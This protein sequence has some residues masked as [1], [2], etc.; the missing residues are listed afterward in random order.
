MLSVL[1]KAPR[2]WSSSRAASLNHL[3]YVQRAR[4]NAVDEV[5]HKTAKAFENI[6]GSLL[7]NPRTEYRNMRVYQG[8]IKGVILDWAGTVLD[9]GVYSPAV[10]FLKV[11]DQEGVPITMEEAREPMGRHKKVH[12]RMVTQIDSVRKRWR[13]KFGRNPNEEDVE[14]MFANF[15]PQQLACL[16]EYSQMITGAV[17]TVDILQKDLKLKI[18]STTGFT[19]PMVDILKKIAAEHGYVPDCY[20]AADEVPQAR[21]YP[22]M[23]WLNAIKLDINPIAAIVKVD[24]TVDG[25]RE[26]T[27]AGCWSVGLARTGNYVALNEDEI[28][29]LTEEEYELKLEK[30]YETLANAGSHYV[31]DSIAELPPVIEDI[32]RRLAS[33]ERP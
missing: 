6:S 3:V 4:S 7:I 10:V 13:E 2:T 14:R 16:S 23:V 27:S 24:D 29:A 31:I 32:N 22:Y 20:V 19:T 21:P 33:G 28:D 18:G 15:V 1:R 26:G 25:V 8:K 30:S 11:F 5:C 17:D 9:C 12:I